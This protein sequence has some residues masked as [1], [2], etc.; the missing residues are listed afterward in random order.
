MDQE[1]LNYLTP[2]QR[3]RYL[4]MQSLFEQ[5]G[6]AIVQEWAQV[7]IK[8]ALERG[9]NSHSWEANRIAWGERLV[10]EILAQMEDIN[11]REYTTL[12]DQNRAEA[13][14]EQI[15]ETELEHE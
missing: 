1:Q 13:E 3:E 9:A 6:W 14:E 2:Q 11:E 10:Y 7:N 12:A 4:K 15:L 8:D 5:P